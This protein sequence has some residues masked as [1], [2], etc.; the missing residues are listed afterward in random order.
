MIKEITFN[1]NGTAK[2]TQKTKKQKGNPVIRVMYFKPHTKFD[3][4]FYK[5]H[6]NVDW[7]MNYGELHDT[8]GLMGMEQSI[9]VQ[10]NVCVCHVLYLLVYCINHNM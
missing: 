6:L 7:S 3:V 9:L 10:L 8:H 4:T 1:E 2:F 5:N